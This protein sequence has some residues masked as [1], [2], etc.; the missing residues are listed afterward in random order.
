[1][2]PD[3]SLR[4]QPSPARTPAADNASPPPPVQP[5]VQGGSNIAQPA[6]PRTGFVYDG[7]LGELYGIFLPNLL[8]TILTLTIF[9]FWAKTRMRR[10]L[11]SRTSL[12]G[13]RFEY[14]G[15]GGEMFLGFLIVMPVYLLF[16]FGFQ[17]AYYGLDI[18][19]AVLVGVQIVGAFLIFYLTFVAQYAAQRYRL[20]RTLWRGIRG[21]MTGSAWA[22]GFKATFFAL[23]TGIT[24][25]LALP[26]TQMRLLSDRLNHSYFG[27]AKAQAELKSG[28]VF[29]TYIVGAVCAVAG[30]FLVIFLGGMIVAATAMALSKVSA[31]S[32]SLEMNLA[33]N[34][35]VMIAFALMY[36]AIALIYV[37]AFSFYQVA[38]A[39]E[40]AA[41]LQLGG[42]RFAT[43]VTPGRVMSRYVGN[44]LIVVFT[45]GLGLPIAIHRTMLFLANNIEVIGE[46][47]GSEITHAN[48][49]RPKVGEGLLEA[50]DPGIL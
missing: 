28:P 36:V 37:L 49:E 11:W 17:A 9:R 41:K 12:N 22:W 45:L 42:L 2:T 34:V 48:L 5:P 1:M 31:S 8:W 23:L 4:L 13:D 35:S 29:V 24:F 16:I 43:P 27:D 21:G 15:T 18:S 39:R 25:T 26:W 6:G 19:D 32:G 20:T 33:A 3:Q 10:Y 40:V 38:I 7:K 46:I 30:T 14:T 44:I 47:E 50:F